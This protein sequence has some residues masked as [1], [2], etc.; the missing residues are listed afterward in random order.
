LTKKELTALKKYIN[1]MLDECF[2]GK[3]KSSA[4]TSIF[5]VLKNG[6]FRLVVDYH[7]FNESTFLNSLQFNWSII[8]LNIFII[9]KSSLKL[10]YVNI[11]TLYTK[12]SFTRVYGHFKNLVMPFKIK[13]LLLFQFFVIQITIFFLW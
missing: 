13:N 8:C 1:E 2:V 11:S 5:F 6:E 12:T 3:S 4:N 9:V 7:R 10:I